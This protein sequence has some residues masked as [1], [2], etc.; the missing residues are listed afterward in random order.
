MGEDE[1]ARYEAPFE[2]VRKH[3]L[4]KREVDRD[5]RAKALWWQHQRIRP[6][7]RRAVRSLSR[8]IVTPETSRRRIFVWVTAPILPD[9]KL[10]VIAR[11]DDFT[12][13]V[14]HSRIHEVWAMRMSR[15]QGVGNDPVYAP[16]FTLKTF[17]LPWSP[18]A[19]AASLTKA[20]RDAARAVAGAASELDAL[21]REWLFPASMVRQEPDLDPRWP[22]LLVPKDAAAA[23]TLKKRTLT[24]LYG[25]RPGWLDLAHRRLDAA[26]A[27]AYGWAPNLRDEEILA[28]LLELNL[29]R[30]A[31]HDVPAD[32]AA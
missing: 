20:Q 11:D 25:A 2:Y 22:R 26:V 9:N 13:G 5:P 31:A 24:N 28:R 10:V 16:E 17:P 12:F 18:R 27:E 1:A 4:P 29:A 6:A 8:F 30:P 19:E 32:E 23:A 14:L 15:R 3:V 21:R 7:M